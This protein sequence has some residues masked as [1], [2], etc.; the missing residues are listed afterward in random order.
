MKTEV[1]ETE[2]EFYSLIDHWNSLLKKSSSD[3]IYLTH[4]WLHCWWKAFGNGRRP[5]IL[6]IKDNDQA[7]GIVPLLVATISYRKFFKIREISFWGNE[8]S[9]RIDFI[10]LAGF[11]QIVIEA[12][13]EYLF[14]NIQIWDVF[15]LAKLPEN[16]KTVDILCKVLSK[17]KV[18]FRIAESIKSPF[19]DINSD[20]ETYY[21]TRTTKFRKGMRNKINRMGRYTSLSGGCGSSAEKT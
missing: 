15:S 17:R 13:I 6:L 21:A 12:L 8:I 19:L 4:E 11:E 7:I 2:K 5:F 20:W 10:C 18:T 9:P 14:K 1:I 3:H 16:S